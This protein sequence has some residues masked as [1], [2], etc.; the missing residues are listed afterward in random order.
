VFISDK[1]KV[2]DVSEQCEPFDSRRI[3]S[4]EKYTLNNMLMR[5]DRYPFGK[6]N[7]GDR[8]VTVWSDR[9]EISAQFNKAG[10]KHFADQPGNFES[11]ARFAGLSADAFIAWAKD[12][13]G[14]TDEVTGAQLVRFT[15]AS[16]QYPSYRL[17]LYIANPE[18]PPLQLYSGNNAPNVK[19]PKE[20]W[21][22]SNGFIDLGNGRIITVRNWSAA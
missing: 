10:V 16:S 9:S 21:G 3:Y 11:G 6:L 8:M 15:D 18:H 14:I 7:P 5:Q 19:Q 13:A 20:K 12:A 2:Y 22:R 4:N 17:N 1:N